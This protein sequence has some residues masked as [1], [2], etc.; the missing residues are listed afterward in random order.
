LTGLSISIPGVEVGFGVLVG[1][2]VSVGLGVCV[3]LV[4][5]DG[6]GDWVGF[7][8]FV[9]LGVSI[10]LGCSS[11]PRKNLGM[12]EDSENGSLAG[13]AVAVNVGVGGKTFVA[14]AQR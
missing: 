12:S 5:S 3:G 4:V 9:D 1:F 11:L 13:A 6:F 8:V 14:V 2:G 10:D 7:G